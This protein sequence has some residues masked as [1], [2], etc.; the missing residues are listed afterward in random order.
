MRN[1]RRKHRRSSGFSLIEVLIAAALLLLIAV[2]VLPLFTRSIENNLLG[3]DALRESNAASD[4]AEDLSA[5]RFNAEPV[6]FA[7]AATSDT[8]AW[9]YQL[10][11]GSAWVD[12]IPAGERAQI[13]R[14]AVLRQYQI[15]IDGAVT[16]VPGNAD[17]G[18]IHIKEIEMQVGNA[19]RGRPIDRVAY[20]L[21]LRK[22][23]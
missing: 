17:P 19:R 16:L 12:T 6:S 20:T 5:A 13:S 22:A 9:S 15:Q 23:F 11:E 21:N 1:R 18:R 14:R 10:L 2:G 8:G 7:T 3:N 4:G